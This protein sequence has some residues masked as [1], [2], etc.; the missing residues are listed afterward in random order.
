M[1]NVPKNVQVHSHSIL[2]ILW[3]YTHTYTILQTLHY[4]I[5]KTSDNST[6]SNTPTP[7]LR[8]HLLKLCDVVRNVIWTYMCSI[9]CF[10]FFQIENNQ[11]PKNS[12][13][14]YEWT[15]ALALV[16]RRGS[17]L[18]VC[19]DAATGWYT[20]NTFIDHGIVSPVSADRAG[21]LDVCEHILKW[22]TSP[23]Q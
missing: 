4:K 20:F 15:L 8:L 11:Y 13:I 3:N 9:G 1:N 19:L 7:S 18:I 23:K 22:K 14:I 12:V 21:S 16:I 2:Q 17:S 6:T 5:L 10:T